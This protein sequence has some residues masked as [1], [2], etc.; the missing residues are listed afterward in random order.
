MLIILITKSIGWEAEQIFNLVITY[1]RNH[2][3]AVKTA[4]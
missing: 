1:N 2:I 3:R 4:Y